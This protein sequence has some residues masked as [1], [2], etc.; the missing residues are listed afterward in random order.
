[1]KTFED[2]VFEQHMHWPDCKHALLAFDNGYGISVVTGSPGPG[3]FSGPYANTGE[4]ECAV[5]TVDSKGHYDLCYDTPITDDVLTHL[6]KTSVKR[7]IRE[8]Q[9]LPPCL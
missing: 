2:L 4:Y 5:M 1:M 9:E 8:I 7:V 6:S 3:G